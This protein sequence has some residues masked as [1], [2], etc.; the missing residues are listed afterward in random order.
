MVVRVSVRERQAVLPAAGN[1]CPKL[2]GNR[3]LFRRAEAPYALFSRQPEPAVRTAKPGTLPNA[4]RERLAFGQHQVHA[5]PVS[6]TFSMR[7]F[8]GRV[9][10]RH[11]GHD[12]RARAISSQEALR[13]GPVNA[14]RVAK[15][16]GIHN[17]FGQFVDH[18][19]VLGK[20]LH[21]TLASPGFK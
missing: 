11:V 3:S 9:E 16:V 20:C 10:R 7:H 21:I 12:R 6:K 1:L 4:I 13:N 19:V 14:L 2:L 17:Q 8:A 5:H 18:T 15:V